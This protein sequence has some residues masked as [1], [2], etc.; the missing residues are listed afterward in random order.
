VGS[1]VFYRFNDYA[2]GDELWKTDP[3]DFAALNAGA[4]TIGATANNDI[5]NI[6]SSGG[7]VT[8]TLNGLSETFAPGAF[9]SIQLLSKGGK[10]T[11][12][13]TSGA[14]TFGSNLRDALGSNVTVNIASGAS[15]IFNDTQRLAALNLSGSAIARLAPNGN[16]TL[17]VDSLSLSASSNLDLTDNDLVVNNGSYSVIRELVRAGFGN[18]TGISSSTASSSQTLALFDNAHVGGGNWN[19]IPIGANAVVAKFTYF[20]DANID[21]QVTGDDY[22]VI[23]ANLNTA[24][25]PGIEW[26]RGD[27]NRDGA[28]TGDD[29]TVID[30]RL[31][32]GVGNPLSPS[33]VRVDHRERLE[34]RGN[35]DLL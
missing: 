29:Y 4:L 5:I 8:V 24:P 3:P 19:G 21:G 15:A 2:H 32:S 7:A 13:I 26:L 25:P 34:I 10:D 18:S 6:S 14:H 9:S 23:D 22:T 33:S 28:I 35:S 12:N 17:V 1:T 30:A 20:G 31:G 27:M 16:R 11:I